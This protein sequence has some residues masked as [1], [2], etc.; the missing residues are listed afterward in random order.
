MTLFNK[1]DDLLALPVFNWFCVFPLF[2]CY[3]IDWYVCKHAC[4]CAL[5]CVVFLWRTDK[6][7]IDIVYNVYTRKW[8]S[9]DIV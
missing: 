1:S 8:I 7:C 3:L 6:N 4:E 5:A 9:N 2:S